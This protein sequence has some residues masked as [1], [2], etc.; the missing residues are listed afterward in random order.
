MNRVDRERAGMF[1]WDKPEEGVSACF[2]VFKALAY[3]IVLG[4]NYHYIASA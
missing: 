3:H 2:G 1:T 4:L